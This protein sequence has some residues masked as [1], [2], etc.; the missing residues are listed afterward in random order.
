MTTILDYG[1]RPYAYG[2]GS[3]EANSPSSR[4]DLSINGSDESIKQQP[5][6]YS[7]DGV[8]VTLSKQQASGYLMAEKYAEIV[9]AVTQGQPPFGSETDSSITQKESAGLLDL[10]PIKL[11]NQEDVAAYEEQLMA[12]LS[13]LGVDTS[14]PINLSVAY[15]GTVVVNN[16]H[17]DKDAIEAVFKED[18]DLRNGFVQTS[19][20]YLFGEIA[21]LSEQWAKKIESG[22]SEEAANLWLIDAV[23]NA[24]SKSSRGMTFEKGHFQDPFSGGNANTVAIKAYQS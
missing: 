18:M 19:N 3:T 15:D 7:N 23:K 1:L 13:S 11:F 16:D 21:S 20:F 24:V 6:G 12:K 5:L 2:T 22:V 10:D 9:D 17:P 14:I 4:A 8:R